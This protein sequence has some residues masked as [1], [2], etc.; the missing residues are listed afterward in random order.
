MRVNSDF[1]GWGLFLILLGSIPLAVRQGLIETDT[2]TRA[3]QLWPLILIGIGI[4][5]VL[6]RT[7]AEF[8]GG[9][10]VAGTFGILAGSF[11]AVGFAGFGAIGNIGTGC[12]FGGGEG[13]AFASQ[14]GQLGANARVRMELNCGEAVI[15]AAPG[16]GWTLAGTDRDGDGPDVRQ[17]AD[18]LEIR[19]RDRRGIGWGDGDSWQIGLPTESELDLEISLNAGEVNVDLPGAQLRRTDV[20][21]NAGSITL[22]L[23]GAAAMQTLNASVNAGSLS[24]SLPPTSLSGSVSANAGAI[25]LC[26]SPG[27]GLRIRAE[28]NIVASYN[29]A[30]RGLLRTGNVW[31]SP[32]WATAETRIDLSASANA[33]SVTLNPEGGCG[34]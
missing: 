9:L 14:S 28:D 22:N 8:L 12:G 32:D 21:V 34:D 20:Q 29:F 19:S 23:L 3:W 26:V 18:R 16:S 15:T 25:E 4:G 24:I 11:L 30:E 13:T 6:R 33:G 7:S 27:T 5:L 10:I 2:L 31:E 1:L 17:S